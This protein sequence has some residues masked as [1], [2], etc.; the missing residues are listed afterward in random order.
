MSSTAAHLRWLFHS[1]PPAGLRTANATI[2]KSIQTQIFDI[3]YLLTAC[4]GGLVLKAALQVLL[5]NFLGLLS[6]DYQRWASGETGRKETAAGQL[7]KSAA[8]GEPSHA[9]SVPADWVPCD[10]EGHDIASN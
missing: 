2:A 10:A 3:P 5:P 8:A 6:A 1:R 9:S 4:A 7:V